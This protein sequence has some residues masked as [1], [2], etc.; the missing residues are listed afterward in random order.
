VL[1][2]S[3]ARNR[4]EIIS[5]ADSQELRFIDELNGHGNSDVEAKEIAREIKHLK[6]QQ[7]SIEVKKQI[8]SLY[9]KLDSIQFKK[10]YMALIIDKDSDYHRAKNGFKI[11]GVEYV[12]LLGTNGGVKNSTIVFVSNTVGAETI[13]RIENGRDMKKP[14]V[15]AKLEAYKA[16]VCSGSIEVSDPKGVLVVPDCVTTFLDDYIVI[17][18]EGV[19]E[20][21]LDL[22]KQQPVELIDSDGYGLMLPS[23]ALQWSLDAEEHYLPSGMCIRNSWTKGMLFTFDFH[24]FAEKVSGSYLVKDIWGNDVDIR[25]VD[26]ILTGSMLKL[27]DSYSSWEDYWSN[28]IKNKYTFSVTKMCPEKLENERN[29]NYQFIQTFNLTDADIAELVQPTISEIRDVMGGDYQKSILFLKGVFLRDENIEQLECDYAKALMIEPEMIKDPFVRSKIRGMIRKRINDA[30]V[31][32]LKTH[33]NFAIVSGDPYSLCQSMFGLPVTGLLKA[34]ESYHKYWLDSQ[35]DTVVAF[36]A[37]MTSHNNI[38]KLHIVTN[39]VM[40]YWYQYMSTCVILNSWDMTCH[41]CNGM[42]KDSDMLLTTDNPVLLHRMVELPAIQCVQR[43]AAKIVPT[44]EDFIKA[45]ISSFGDA[46]GSITNRI[47][48]MI[49]LLAAYPE[50]STEYEILDYRIKC[51]Q[52][53]QQ[54][55]IDKSKGIVSK[56]MPK[57]WCDSTKTQDP[58]LKRIAAHK[59]PYFMK[60]IYP[61][62]MK[63]YNTFVSSTNKKCLREFGCTA[64]ELLF[65]AHRNEAKDDY[66]RW[67]Y[68]R[69]PVGV[70]P[71]VMNRI[72]WLIEKEFDRQDV[73]FSDIS[74]DKE[75]IKSGIGY[76]QARYAEI[77]KIYK[78]YSAKMRDYMREKSNRRIVDKDDIYVKRMCSVAD[79]SKQCYSVCPSKYEL[80][81]ILVDMCYKTNASKQF[82][83]DMCGDVIIETLLMKRD[84]TIAYPVADE[85]GDIVFNGNKY[86]MKYK[87][88]EVD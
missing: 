64:D 17:N 44:E 52:L 9:E 79:F 66:I 88:L 61:D 31:G 85:F 76:S 14:F 54:N 34:G 4:N 29:L 20:P 22:V 41:A 32:V 5:L 81:D 53:F 3:E 11:N 1:P 23:R 38:R 58:M 69:I 63:D 33:G 78:D 16:L 87:L 48:T 51:G 18:D 86:S 84:N 24:A 27:W 57:E 67:Y 35:V 80:C 75:L 10:D 70:N 65:D 71:C 42:D 30:K 47:T 26:V 50:G 13:Q 59:K 82:V 37:P 56:P 25:S 43:K 19:D 62:T 8:R 74:F 36:R 6:R 72:C 2:L 40:D 73:G 55:A 49:E 39:K 83:W 68:E 45:N 46:I 28:C 7:T 21:T 60:Y 77:E 15:P 12:R